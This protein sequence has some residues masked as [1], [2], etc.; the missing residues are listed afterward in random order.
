MWSKLQDGRWEC[1]SPVLL[2]GSINTPVEAREPL[3]FAHP[4]D[5]VVPKSGPITDIDSAKKQTRT[6]YEIADPE[7][8]HARCAADRTL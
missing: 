5:I 1:T 7:R 8:M 3:A 4:G 2:Y 6:V